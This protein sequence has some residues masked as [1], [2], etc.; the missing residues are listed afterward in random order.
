MM[1][2]TLG[3]LKVKLKLS[4]HWQYYTANR[5]R[6]DVIVTKRAFNM[7]AD[8]NQKYCVDAHIVNSEVSVMLKDTSAGWMLTNRG[9]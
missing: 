2:S 4:D 3:Q 7:F 1:V 6:N 5:V 8:T 9:C